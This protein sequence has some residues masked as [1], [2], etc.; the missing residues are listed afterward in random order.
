MPRQL[1]GNGGETEIAMCD[2]INNDLERVE[3]EWRNWQKELEI[4]DRG[5]SERK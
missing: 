4:A 1:K 2:C 3:E 5:S